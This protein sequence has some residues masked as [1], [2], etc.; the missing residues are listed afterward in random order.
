ME[1]FKNLFNWKD[2]RGLLLTRRDTLEEME[3]NISRHV[4]DVINR[5]GASDAE[6]LAV[7]NQTLEQL[8]TRLTRMEYKNG[9]L[10][11]KQLESLENQMQEVTDLAR[12]GRVSLANAAL[13]KQNRQ[14]AESLM[15]AVDQLDVVLTAPEES[16][17]WTLFATS[18]RASLLKGLEAA[19]Y[20][21]I[22]LK[23]SLFQ[24]QLAVGVT[25]ENQ[26]SQEW[27]HDRQGPVDTPRPGEI[28]SV[29]KRGYVNQEGAVCRKAQVVTW[30][31]ASQQ[32]EA[33]YVER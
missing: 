25:T 33:V 15:G 20:Y 27:A 30:Q 11:R 24:A 28:I 7:S 1:W 21:E 10:M 19:G 17:Q 23:G 16:T 8:L 2:K 12:E 14:L 31:P 5:Q 26:F 3:K 18:F 32:Q 22:D 29:L 9:E 4:S 13:K 6:K